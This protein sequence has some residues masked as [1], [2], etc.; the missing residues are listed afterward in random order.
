MII[1]KENLLTALKIAVKSLTEKEDAE[2]KRLN[3]SF[4][5]TYRAGLEENID[6]LEKGGTLEIIY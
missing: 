1:H 3:I 2:S 4:R 5:S 6:H